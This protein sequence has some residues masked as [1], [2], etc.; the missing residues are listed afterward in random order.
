MGSRWEIIGQPGCGR[1]LARLAAV[2]II[3]LSTA[4]CSKPSGEG[5]GT[6]QEPS[7]SSS[8][9]RL[10]F[11]ATPGEARGDDATSFVLESTPDLVLHATLRDGSYEGKTLSIHGEDPRGS[12]VWSYPHVQKGASFDAVLPVFGSRAAREHLTG[13]YSF[14]VLA[15]DGAVIAAGKAAFRSARTSIGDAGGAS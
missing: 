2:A 6:D 8:P 7:S 9:V 12:I 1:G 3:A 10:S 4:A 15:P 5:V 13:P 14:E 11:G